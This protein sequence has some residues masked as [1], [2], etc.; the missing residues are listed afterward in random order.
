MIS[1]KNNSIIIII[2]LIL[3]LIVGGYFFIETKK[4]KMKMTEM[5]NKN[6]ANLKNTLIDLDNVS[7]RI[8]NL[9]MNILNAIDK[10]N[11]KL[12]VSDNGD[13]IVNVLDVIELVDIIIN[14]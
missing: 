6:I 5:E 9:E 1:I 13:G 3:L 8:S 4:I 14:G 12:N 11:V 10:S 7:N 2:S